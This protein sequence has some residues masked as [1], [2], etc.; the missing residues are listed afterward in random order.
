MNTFQRFVVLRQGVRRHR[1]AVE[2]GAD[3]RIGRRHGGKRGSG[4]A[5]V[6]EDRALPAA[7]I[8]IEIG[9]RGVL[10]DMVVELHGALRSMTLW[11]GRFLTALRA[12]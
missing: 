2:R 6:E 10:E 4:L 11:F 3:R 7:G 9:V 1:Q 8:A 5:D 12:G